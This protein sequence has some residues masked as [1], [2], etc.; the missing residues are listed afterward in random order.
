MEYMTGLHTRRII[1]FFRYEN[2][3]IFFF[4]LGFHAHFLTTMSGF[5][6]QN[7][8]ILIKYII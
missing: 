2:T 5:I 6:H 3:M 8:I 1:H 4:Q 7:A